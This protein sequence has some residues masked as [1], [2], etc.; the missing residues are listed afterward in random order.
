MR[1]PKCIEYTPRASEVHL[2]KLHLVYIIV[3]MGAK[4]ACVSHTH[5]HTYTHTHTNENIQTKQ[6]N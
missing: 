1:I 6:N 2:I 4:E 3:L 5:T